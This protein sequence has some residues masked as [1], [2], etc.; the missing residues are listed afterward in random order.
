MYFL[1]FFLPSR[2]LPEIGKFLLRVELESTLTDVKRRHYNRLI[3]GCN[4]NFENRFRSQIQQNLLLCD[5]LTG[6][7][8][9]I[10]FGFQR[11][12]QPGIQ[13]RFQHL[14][15]DRAGFQAHFFQIPAF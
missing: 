12:V 11:A 10:F 6:K 14:A 1:L 8:N 4:Q 15:I 2:R 13:H 7:F 9:F 3:D 5:E